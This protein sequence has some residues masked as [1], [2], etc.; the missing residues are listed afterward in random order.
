MGSR[1][2]SSRRLGGTAAALP[3]QRSAVHYDVESKTVPRSEVVLAVKNVESGGEEN[4]LDVESGGE[5]HVLYLTGNGMS[6]DTLVIH[7]VYC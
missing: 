6:V 5:E 4:V 1:S 3:F 2:S 7:F